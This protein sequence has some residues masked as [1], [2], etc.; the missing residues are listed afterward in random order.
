M[1]QDA[2]A[3]LG[4]TLAPAHDDGAQERGAAVDAAV[5]ATGEDKVA[6][7]QAQHSKLSQAGAADK[8]NKAVGVREL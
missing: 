3:D 8:A 2:A 7:L 1:V 5:V 4:T 6:R